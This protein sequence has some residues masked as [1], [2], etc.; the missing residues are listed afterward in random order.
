MKAGSYFIFFLLVLTI[1]KTSAQSVVVNGYINQADFRDEWT[2]LVVVDDDVDMRGWTIR[3]NNSSQNGWQTPVR[4]NSIPFWQHM[5]RG[6]II[7]LWHRTLSSTGVTHT[8]DINANDG[9]LEMS[10]QDA[11]YFTGGDFSTNNTMNIA[12]GG[13]IIE[14]R[15][16]AS[17]HIHALGH[18]NLTSGSSWT[19]MA[20]PK[21]NHFN[22]TNNGDAVYVCPGSM[23]SEFDGPQSIT[24]T[25]KNNVTTTFGLPNLC[26]SS[27]SGNRTFW[28]SLRQPDFTAQVVTPSPIIPGLPGSLSFSWTAATDPYPSDGSLR[29]LVLRNTVNTFSSSPLDGS[30]YSIGSMIGSA[31]VVGIINNSGITTFT[32]NSVMNGNKYYY[33]VYAFRYGVDNLNGN[34]FDDARGSAYNEDNYVFVNWPTSPLPVELLSFNATHQK[35]GVLIDWHTKSELNNDFFTL[36][37]STDGKTYVAITTVKGAGTSTLDQDYYFVDSNPVNGINYYRLSQTDFD[38]THSIYYHATALV[39]AN[40]GF[41]LQAYPNPF[42]SNIYVI[43][44]SDLQV[45]GTLQLLDAKGKK[46]KILNCFIQR[47]YNLFEL[48]TED[49]A[50]GVYFLSLQTESM[51]LHDKLVK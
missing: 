50:K 25:A 29:Y 1:I 13:D 11:T 38:G 37:K 16:A 26:V 20:Q 41:T 22:S 10:I 28:K 24:L 17:V 42:T 19:A 46:L 18:Y 51:F 6:T 43:V 31:Q 8:N 36:E 23:L 47:G 34:N 49:L 48:K 5:R 3:D 12:A 32:D 45:D 39:K 33:R 35:E 9:Y 4:F 30:S 27:L 21:L 2:E 7:M 15:N 40:I 14:L 44:N